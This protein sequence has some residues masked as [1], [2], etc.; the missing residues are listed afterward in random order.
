MLTTW[1][2]FSQNQTIDAAEVY[3]HLMYENIVYCKRVQPKLQLTS[4][5]VYCTMRYENAFLDDWHRA[6]FCGNY[7]NNDEHQDKWNNESLI[8]RF[9]LTLQRR[10]LQYSLSLHEHFLC[11]SRRHGYR[12]HVPMQSEISACWMNDN[13]SPFC[14]SMNVGEA[15][16][17]DSRHKVQAARRTFCRLFLGSWP[18]P[19]P[20]LH[21]SSFYGLQR[22]A[23]GKT[24]SARMIW[25]LD[26]YWEHLVR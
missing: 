17:G 12:R 22:G 26:C 14:V 4:A 3:Y 6:L 1:H 20:S 5:C 25:V 15:S 8:Q 23:Q 10:V 13:S 24:R 9:K 21:R 11:H 19:L 16:Y 2:P 18:S 7:L